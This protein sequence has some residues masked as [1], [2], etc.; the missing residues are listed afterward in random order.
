MKSE[1]I[2]FSLFRTGGIVDLTLLLIIWGLLVTLMKLDSWVYEWFERES[3]RDSWVWDCSLALE[4][5][6]RT[7]LGW[8]GE[9]KLDMMVT[10]ILI[11]ESFNQTWAI[12]KIEIWSKNV[13]FIWINSLYDL[14]FLI[15]NI[16]WNW[17]QQKQ[18]KIFF[19]LTMLMFEIIA[20]DS[21]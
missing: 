15:E 12:I 10:I 4:L 13:I 18:K 5:G 14:Y 2:L 3:F 6:R 19:G 7:I 8:G 1:G 11:N 9:L 17:C 16:D 20:F 21:G